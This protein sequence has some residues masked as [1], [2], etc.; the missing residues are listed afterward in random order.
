MSNS[1]W[2]A[3]LDRRAWHEAGHLLVGM[4]RCGVAHGVELLDDGNARTVPD[5]GGS[6]PVPTTE[7]EWLDV[8]AWNVA[9]KVAVKWAI[10]RDLLDPAPVGEESEHGEHG[11]SGG[12][13]S[14]EAHAKSHAAKVPSM[15]EANALA[16][17]QRRTLETV[18][19][20]SD[21]LEKLFWALFYA[22]ALSSAQVRSILS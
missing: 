8:V 12:P 7:D 13:E 5:P 19:M 14:D 11:Y 3:S 16:E 21:K 10:E 17:G 15:P 20:E 1:I 9:G 4:F 2:V 18:L 22:G 6:Y